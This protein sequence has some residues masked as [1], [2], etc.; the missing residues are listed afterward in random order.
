MKVE[1]LMTREPR[2]C[3]STGTLNDAAQVLWECDCGIVPIVER[4]DGAKRLVGVV[5][6]RDICMAAYTTGQSLKEIP[7]A[8]VMSKQLRTVSSDDS[9]ESAEKTMRTAQ[10]RRLPVVDGRGALL[11]ILSLADIARE[12]ARERRRKKPDVSESE[13]AATLGAIAVPRA[14]AAA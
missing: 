1:E 10:L 9:I 6:D 2:A 5:T 8:Q 11:G 12:A 4:E 13:V 7:V 3:G 14:G